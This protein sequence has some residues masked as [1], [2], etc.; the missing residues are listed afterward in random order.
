[1]FLESL[2]VR[3]QLNICT[4]TAAAAAAAAAAE[5]HISSI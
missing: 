2:Q 1:M 5:Q 3:Q 4:S